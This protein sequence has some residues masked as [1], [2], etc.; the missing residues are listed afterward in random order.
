[1]DGNG[2]PLEIWIPCLIASWRVKASQ[3]TFCTHQ[4]SVDIS[5]ANEYLIRVVGFRQE[6]AVTL[7]IVLAQ[8]VMPLLALIGQLAPR[9]WP[10]SN[11]PVWVFRISPYWSP[12][13]MS[14]KLCE[15]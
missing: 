4:R 10:R 8:F 7:T 2:L 12:V 3:V 13:T 6:L 11:I 9:N 15:K 14:I 1:M 5:A